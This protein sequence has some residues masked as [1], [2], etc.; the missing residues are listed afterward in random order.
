V[1]QIANRKTTA[2]RENVVKGMMNQAFCGPLVTS[3]PVK[4]CLMQAGPAHVLKLRVFDDDI[5]LLTS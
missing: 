2:N 5:T 3:F 4:K 1:E